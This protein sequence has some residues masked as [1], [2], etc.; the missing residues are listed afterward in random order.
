MSKSRGKTMKEIVTSFDSIRQCFKSK[1]R[2][3]GSWLLL[4]CL[5]AFPLSYAGNVH[6][7]DLVEASSTWRYLDD[8]SDQGT[9]WRTAG[10]DDSSWSS[11]TA[12]LGYG[13]GDEATVVS[14]GSDP[15]HKHVTTYFRQNF[16]VTDPSQ[17]TSLEL[18]LIRDDGAV[19]YINGIEVVRTN[20]PSGDIY[21]DT[22]A[23][24]HGN[25]TV[26]AFPLSNS[27]LVVGSNIIAVEVHQVAYSS[28]DIS[29]NLQLSDSQNPPP[30]T[31]LVARDT[32]WR[33]LDDGSNQGVVWRE[34]L[35]DD[36]SWSSGH[37]ELG[38][39]DGD[40][41]TIVG[42]GSDSYNKYITTYF[43]QSFDVIDPSQITSLELKLLR[44]D[45]AVVYINGIEVVRSNMPYGDVNHGTLADQPEE[46]LDVFTLR[47]DSL[48]AGSNSI[49]VEIHQSSGD[50][51]D[52][53]F[54]LELSESQTPPP[55][56]PPTMLVE[57][58]S[59]WRNLDDGT[60]QGLA[61]RETVFDDSS[62][63]TGHAELGYGDG[64]EATVVDYGNDPSNKYITTYFRQN[65]D[66]TD[67]SQFIS[68]E[69]KL[70]RDDGAVVYINGTEV[71]RSNM[72]YGDANHDTLANHYVEET[73]DTFA[74]RTDTLLIGDNVVAVEIHQSDHDS[75]DISFNLELSESQNSPPPSPP[76][77][78]VE[79]NSLWLYLDDG[80]DQGITWRA[81]GYDDSHW[82]SGHAELG[83]GE[84][85]EATIVSYG[86][87]PYNKHITTYFRQVFE[88][89]N[90]GQID[91]LDL[92]LLY[93]DG[94]VVY[95]NGIEVAR[96]NLPDGNVN[97]DTRANHY[98]EETLESFALN[99]DAL[100]TGSN[101]ITVE[102]HQ[103]DRY[104]SDISF[105]LELRPVITTPIANAGIDQ[106]ADAGDMVTLDGSG[107]FDPQG[108]ALSYLWTVLSEPTGS[109]V[110]LSSAT[111]V[112]PTF[113]P[114]ISGSYIIE[115]VVS[116]GISNSPVDTVTVNV[117]TTNTQPLANAGID[118]TGQAGDVITLN[119]S[120]SSDADGDSLTYQW[121]LTSVPVGSTAVLTINDVAMS[122]FTADIAGVYQ[123]QLIVND[124]QVDSNND[125]VSINIENINTIPVANAGPDQSAFANNLVTLDGSAS[126]D[127]DGDPLT[128][129]WSFTVVP[130]GSNVQLSDATI[131]NPTFTPD[132][133]GQYVIQLTVNDQQ[134]NSTPDS[135]IVNALLPNTI[136][137]ANAGPDQSD[138]VG[139]LILLDGSASTDADGDA[140]TFNWSLISQPATSSAS[141]DN[142]ATVNSSFTIDAPGNY[143]VQLYVNDGQADSAPDETIISTQNSRPV[144]NAGS[145]QI[146][147][148]GSNFQLDASAST[149]ADNDTLTWQWSITSQ[150]TNSTAT[151]SDE[152]VQAPT[153]VPD[154]FGF[155]VFQLIV[156]DAILDS[157]PDTQ[158]LQVDPLQPIAIILNSPQDQLNTNQAS[159]NFIGSLN[160]AATL[161]LNGQ[162]VVVQ[163][164]LSFS[165]PFT[166]QEGVNLFDLL[167]IDVVNGQDTL[168]RQIILDTSIPA[169]PNSGLITLSLPDA[170][171]QVTITGANG[172][173]EAF[174]QVV[175][176]NIRTNEVIIVIADANGAFSVLIDAQP[177]DS[178][179]IVSQDSA[180]NQSTTI[181]VN[182]VALPPVIT[183]AAT[184]S[185]TIDT[186]YIY[187]V[188]ATDPNADPLTY[189]LTEKPLGL[190]VDSAGLIT[191]NPINDGNFPV[192]IEV[193]DGNGGIATQSYSINVTGGTAQ[194]PTLGAI[195][196]QTAL[197]GRTL[198]LQLSAN[199]PEGMP[200]EYFAEPMPLP[201]NTLLDSN[202]GLFTFT[203]AADQVG[204]FDITF[205]ATNGR[206]YVDQTITITVPPPAGV[207]QLRGQVLTSNDA[208]LPG[209][210]L[211]MGGIETVSDANGDFFLDNLTVSGSA[212]LLVDGGAASTSAVVYATVPEMINII[213]GTENMLDPAIF[214]LPL[215]VSSADP[216][217]PAQTSIITSSRFTTGL[218]ISEPVTMTIPP[219]AAI[220]DAT[221]Q[222]FVGDIHISRVTD[223]T[224]GP[225]PLPEEFDLGVYI[226]IQPFGVTYP[227]PIEI[228]FPNLENFPTGS[229]L[230]FFALNHETGVM[231]KIGEGLVSA[232]GKTV[233][234]IGGV[235][236]S[237][238]WH[239]IV[240]Q[241]P[242]ATPNNPPGENEPPGCDANAGCK[243][244]RETGNLSEW[245][246]LPSY[247]SLQAARSITLEY[248]S[249]NANPHPILPLISG[250]G[251][252]APAP[253]LMSMRINIDGIEMGKELFSTVRIEP[254]S[255]RGQFK[256]TR[257]AI[258][259]NATMID[260]GIHNYELDIDCYFPISRRQTTVSE[261]IIIHNERNSV[262][263][264]GWSIPGLQRVYE[265]SS[266]RVMLT[267]GTATSLIF[268]PLLTTPDLNDF[269]SPLGD[270]SS[271]TRLADTTFSRR[272]K[273]G[274]RYIFS[275]E[276]LLIQAIDRNNNTTTY[277][278]DTQQRLISITDPVGQAFTLIYSVNKLASITDPL[279][280]ITQFEHDS[281]GNLIGIIEPNG[282]RRSFEYA[283]N[284]NLMTAQIDQRLNR[285]E[286][287]YDFADRISE[288]LLPDGS[289]P[290]FELG[291]TKGLANPAPEGESGDGSRALPTDAPPLLEDIN[292][293]YADHNGNSSMV[294]T[295]LRHKPLSRT[296]SVGR[297]YVYNRDNDSNATKTTRPNTSTI[298]SA[299]DDRGNRLTKT[300][301]FNA[302][303]N[304]TTY[305]NF[306]LVTSY[307]NPNNHTTTYNRDLANGDVSS[308]VNHLG[309][310]TTYEYDSRG[311]VERMVM[312]NLL[313][314]TYTYNAQGLAETI[315]ET[316]P[317][318]SSG[319]VR[320]T[321]FSYD[322]A[323]QMIQTI[324]PDDIT[325]NVEYDDKGRR[326]KI[327]DNLNQIIE[328]TYDAHNNLVKTDTENS[329]GSLALTVQKMFDTRNRFNESSSPHIGSENS[330]AKKMFDNNS[331]VVG[332]TDPNSNNATNEYDAEDRLKS[333]NHRLNGVT[334]YDYDTNDRIIK[335][336]APNGVETGYTYDLL[337]RKLSEVS[338]DRGTVTYSYDVS[339]NVLSV[340]D[341]RGIT[342]T[343]IYD[344]LERPAS[345]TY[346][347]SIVGKTENVT[348]TYDNC[349]FGLGKLCRRG[350]E[351]GTWDYEYD[352][353]GN[354][355]KQT[356]VELGISY[357]TE[358]QYDN[359]NHITQMTYP[360][361]RVVNYNRD[362]IR[363]I[364][365][366]NTDVNNVNT[367]VVSN[368]QYRA[369][370]QMTQ[371][372]FGNGLVDNRSYDLQGRL[373]TQ[374]LGNIDNRAY[375]FDKNSNMLSRTTTPQ[376]SVYN[377]DALDRIIGDQIDGAETFEYQYDL[378]HN[379]Q[380]KSQTANLAD[381]YDYQIGTNRITRQATFTE[382][383]LPAT[384]NDRRYIYSDTNRIFQV[385]DDGLLNAEYIYN[386]QGQRTRKTIYDNSASP[387][388]NT[389][390]VYHYD[391]AGNLIAETDS[392]GTKQKEYVWMNSSP[393]AQVDTILNIE[394]VYYLHTDRLMT[395]RFATNAS[396]QVSWRWEG[397]AFGETFDQQAGVEVNL[398]F[399]GQYYDKET[400][401]HY[402]WNRYYRTGV[403][404]YITSDPI[405]LD[406]GLNVYAYTENNPINKADSTGKVILPDNWGE[407]TLDCLR[408]RVLVW[409]SCKTKK[410]ERCRGTD[411]CEVLVAKFRLSQDCVF[412]QNLL[413]KRCYPGSDPS[414]HAQVI[415][416]AL[417][418]G[419]KCLRFIRSNCQCPAN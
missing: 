174:S 51:S 62:W 206:F 338:A 399:P 199:D 108:D 380:S 148:L 39:G 130:V 410:S 58:N 250:F 126:S 413:S 266:G 320:I 244:D 387:V 309:H 414:N 212:R 68:L 398:R 27:S 156:N 254:S 24:N 373:L 220:D 74:L 389:V 87:N 181:I 147:T 75:S 386:D 122:M 143:I 340:T 334:T 348:Y 127:V 377:Y 70:L 279:N 268:E 355:T 111:S 219:G 365:S 231:E 50:S 63:S 185:A 81:I 240:P 237:N 13:D 42:Y 200:L 224:K 183:S 218:S 170:N 6:A 29:F 191:W 272:M 195:G 11:G 23:N 38:Y 255:V 49:A 180:G 283:A 10:Y 66:V 106:A 101:I 251:N 226:A 139:N 59:Q 366:I 252:Q 367:N 98:V 325:L 230:D 383:D 26:S 292:N 88:V 390:T 194:T 361:G 223:P 360:T 150:P 408:L 302:A 271:L 209:V 153:I 282:D 182:E 175:I 79:Q 403:G 114:L 176:T 2:E 326:A 394:S 372:T 207:T 278:Y 28:S 233:D 354:M 235:V 329:D 160:H 344:E 214:L 388:T 19:V 208:P 297:T 322:A 321:Q 149:D 190:N 15:Y 342:A 347:N 121:A 409:I 17:I 18:S 93:D 276:G 163:S 400:G 256:N 168:S 80:S 47:T 3:S 310:T 307:T 100:V 213:A 78:L 210:R 197:L 21:S 384:V 178:Y 32:Q 356:K 392:A 274:R 61:W 203:P 262:F 90:P 123:A 187:Q 120:S 358:Y 53:S 55:P 164:D 138:F 285:T 165:H 397:E 118:Q 269:E 193:S 374:A 289:R 161:T 411:N 239:G 352:A 57:R 353:F 205:M 8:G 222:P 359:G 65:F 5:V 133:Q 280:R 339:N 345:K 189:N 290:N 391:M 343:S 60:D 48:I 234:S 113:T 270:F 311:L 82:S 416:D 341:G 332:T 96:S 357:V 102:I 132:L 291:Q 419:T 225:R 351:S 135:V 56:P 188:I 330:I 324:T 107:S 243:I 110:A 34:A 299:F 16:E 91:S 379:R 22:L 134:A 157:A 301:N 129:L 245:H 415:R 20:M 264:A 201:A 54:N 30:P 169:P 146:I 407:N 369:D 284:K 103:S 315:T 241:G 95:I 44:D 105:N 382:G 154:Q 99:T 261:Q 305:D 385:I 204:S 273:D 125:S 33:Y 300:E 312:P 232:D 45:G 184:I 376:T 202:T 331:N 40:E 152:T 71:A 277:Q 346:P 7:A 92:D 247:S 67:P 41:T 196:N 404:R 25:G 275:T 158:T 52:I 337:G 281:E 145:D 76:P 85:D 236:K 109:A 257:P 265:H 104:S 211:E 140:L 260:T 94:A 137:L 371:C 303:T 131:T 308:S 31:V 370:S 155:Y 128:W 323:G 162:A 217:N 97:Y 401:E 396:Q 9:I 313:V 306:S 238:S 86:W 287:F 72:P 12:E 406:G 395:A 228:S 294:K 119:G 116:D 327:T 319:N 405:G 318:S 171:N 317:A 381:N 267:E 198:N 64:D 89:A 192:T 295:D 46:T 253:D 258:Q 286:Y 4:L 141:L 186:Q 362:G 364:E 363:R 246:T 259:F 227:D 378:N 349:T 43:R 263:G 172:S 418:R 167:A 14:Y 221:G 350:D 412:F 335:V 393:V 328:Y 304:Q 124:G 336:T 179:S 159:I 112:T 288:T 1:T 229:R 316:P 144:A 368:I 375:T 216:V 35:F 151:L 166:L 314:I 173:V 84:G 215:D 83:Y 333:N 298:D 402:N 417:N 37:A 69:L 77:V 117:S 36:T 293:Q 242:T 136:P 248:N 73:L 177:G 249:N 115:L 142:P 296:D